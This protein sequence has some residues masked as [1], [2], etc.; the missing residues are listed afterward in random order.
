MSSRRLRTWW[1]TQV[2]T[3]R[4]SRFGAQTAAVSSPT[5]G[6]LDVQGGHRD[7][8]QGQ[9]GDPVA[10][11]RDP[12]PGPVGRETPVPPERG[13]V[14]R[15]RGA[16]RRHSR[17]H[18]CLGQHVAQHPHGAAARDLAV[19]AC[20]ARTGRAA[21]RSPA[22]P[23]PARR[24]SRRTVV[25]DRPADRR[26]SSSSRGSAS[27][28][29]RPGRSS[30]W[31]NI[32]RDS[33]VAASRPAVV[34]GRGEPE[35]P[36]DGL[37]PALPPVGLHLGVADQT[38]LGEVAQVPAGHGGVAPTSGASA[39]AVLGPSTWSR[40]RIASRSG[41]PT[42]ASPGASAPRRRT[43]CSPLRLQRWEN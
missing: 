25:L 13:L 12:L 2:P 18:L 15:H 7:E 3:K 6:A 28:A 38:V 40:L 19:G 41:G 4:D 31:S 8:R 11:L 34:G 29:H 43:G 10:E 17:S 42:P 33:S 37:P 27:R 1:S 16:S 24:R 26:Q 14:R 21:P 23:R 36:T 35:A 20:A 22:P 9:L 5:V 39:V 30:A 32:T